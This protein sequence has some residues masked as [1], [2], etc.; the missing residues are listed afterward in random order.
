MTKENVEQRVGK[1]ESR[2]E[3]LESIFNNKA[4]RS[5]PIMER[6]LA[7]EQQVKDMVK[8]IDIIIN[9]HLP[10]IQ[11]QIDEVKN[12]QAYWTGALAIIQFAISIGLAIYLK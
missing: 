5:E 10:H 8:S 6:Y 3:N 1:V 9:N 2:V 11:G 12:R 7:T 4:M